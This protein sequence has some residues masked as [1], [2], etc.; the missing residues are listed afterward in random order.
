MVEIPH[1][2][3][4]PSAEWESPDGDLEEKM[5]VWTEVLGSLA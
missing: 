5:N 2:E 4:F 1:P 3:R